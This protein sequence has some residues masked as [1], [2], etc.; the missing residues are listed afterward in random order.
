MAKMAPTE[1][2]PFFEVWR[3]VPPEEKLELMARAQSSGVGASL[4]ILI[5]C[6]T[7]SVGLKIPWIFYG[8]FLGIP[9][10]FQFASSKAWRDIK[11]RAML[12]YL[13]AR[14]AARRYAFGTHCQDLTTKLMFKGS[15]SQVFSEEEE[16]QEL[17]AEID[18]KQHRDVWVA[19][20]PDTIVVLSERQGGAQLELAHSID[21]R[22]KVSTRGFEEGERE[23]RAVIL[24]FSG[25]DGVSRKFSLTSRY[26]AA[27]YVFERQLKAFYELRR[28]V[29]E[30]DA[31]AYQS[32]FTKTDSDPFASVTSFS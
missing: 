8:A 32:M 27:L 23:E 28:E 10:I 22:L 9:F 18:N 12:E 31:Q 25:R 11:P 5:V 6:G 4:V 7:V 14:S 21:Q 30:K 20:F 19:L 2:D 29:S 26:P 24:Q 16:T 13:G 15:L 17:E 3:R 1:V